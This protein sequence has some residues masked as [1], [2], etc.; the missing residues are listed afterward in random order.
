[1]FLAPEPTASVDMDEEWSWLIGIDLP[2]VELHVLVR[3]IRDMLEGGLELLGEKWREK[4][5]EKNRRKVFEEHGFFICS[6]NTLIKLF[7]AFRIRFRIQ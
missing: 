7:L 4:K 1:V 5:K 3:P 6:K 2:E